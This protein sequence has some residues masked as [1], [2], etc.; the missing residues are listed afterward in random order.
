MGHIWY[1]FSNANPIY[2]PFTSWILFYV[3]FLKYNLIF[4]PLVYRLTDAAL[5]GFSFHDP[6]LFQNW[7]WSQT[8]FVDDAMKQKINNICDLCCWKK[9]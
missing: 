3:D 2:Q 4:P 1:N 6:F 5:I 9:N 7:N 8:S